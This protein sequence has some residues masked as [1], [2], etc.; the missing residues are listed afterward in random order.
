MPPA[1]AP[2]IRGEV[3]PAST[4]P[5]STNIATT[6]HFP[7]EERRFGLGC[8]IDSVTRVSPNAAGRQRLPTHLPVNRFVVRA[9]ARILV[10]RPIRAEAHTTNQYDV[11]RSYQAIACAHGARIITPQTPPIHSPA[12]SY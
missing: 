6:V 11:A 12:N 4:A 1:A 8:G 9:S 7:R 10:R 5:P 3:H 2:T